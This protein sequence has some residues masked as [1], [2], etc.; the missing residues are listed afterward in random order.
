M[1]LP[2]EP[3]EF[4]AMKP[5]IEAMTTFEGRSTLLATASVLSSISL[6]LFKALFIER[7]SITKATAIMIKIMDQMMTKIIKAI[8]RTDMGLVYSIRYRV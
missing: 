3:S 5:T 1:I 7:M 4:L 8:S 2:M 6:A